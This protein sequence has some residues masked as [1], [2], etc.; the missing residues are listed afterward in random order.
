MASISETGHA[1]NISNFKL[2]I[3]KCTA[4]GG[5]YNP[6]NAELTV[7]N[8]TLLWTS[9]SGAHT[10]VVQ[11]VEAAKDP[12]NQREILYAPLDKLVTRVMNYFESTTSSK[13]IKRD[14]KGI[15]DKIRGVKKGRTGPQD[16]AAG[17]ST[18]QRSYVKRQENF[19]ALIALLTSTGT[20]LPNEA[21]LQLGSL[22]A[23]STQMETAN[24]NIGGILA[25]AEQARV[26]RNHAMY[27]EGTGMVDI[28]QRC[29]KYVKGVFGANAPETKLVSGIKFKR[30]V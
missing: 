24:N 10:A 30:M 14:A 11:A 3:D 5:S 22:T 20:Y 9:V 8:M 21:E 26:A 23:L 28:A 15:A 6:A 2:L 17:L 13:A 12:I 18:S 16:D 19:S 7:A 25:P 4:F 29:K 27:D 1:V